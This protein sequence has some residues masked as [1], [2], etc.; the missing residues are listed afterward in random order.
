MRP[1][2]LSTPFSQFGDSSGIMT[3]A[4][5]YLTPAADTNGSGNALRSRV[6]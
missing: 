4:D 5:H 1:G 3:Y 2:D 6:H